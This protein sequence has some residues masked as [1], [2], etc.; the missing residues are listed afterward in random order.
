MVKRLVVCAAILLL[1]LFTGAC[2]LCFNG[3]LPDGSCTQLGSA[4]APTATST[5]APT[6]AP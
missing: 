3:T 2:Q 4:P 1:A 6:A 5:V